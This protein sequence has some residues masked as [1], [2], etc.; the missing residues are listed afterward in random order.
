MF[1]CDLDVISRIGFPQTAERV[2][3]K[4]HEKDRLIKELEQKLESYRG[5]IYAAQHTDCIYESGYSI[6]SLH[7]TEADAQKA[8]E[9]HR[10]Q[11]REHAKRVLRHTELMDTPEGGV[12]PVDRFL[13]F[14]AWKVVKLEVME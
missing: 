13:R 7:R 12:D 2:K 6:I 4:L 14:E 1:N 3:N 5:S 10:R 11:Q 9:T 8:M